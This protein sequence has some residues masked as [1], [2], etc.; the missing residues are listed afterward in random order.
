MLLRAKVSTSETPQPNI[1]GTYRFKRYKAKLKH[2]SLCR[3][4]IWR[5][6]KNEYPLFSVS[7]VSH[8][9]NFHISL[10]VSG[11]LYPSC[12]R[13]FIQE[14]SVS[15]KVRRNR[16]ELPMHTGILIQISAC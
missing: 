6:N 7:V 3:K 10:S 15:A 5:K 13:G 16:N 9:S 8:V 11:L 2:N 1:S 4:N 12:M 14:K